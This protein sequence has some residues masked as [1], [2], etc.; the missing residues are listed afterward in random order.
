MA[1]NL[2]REAGTLGGC[3][4]IPGQIL[5]PCTSITHSLKICI[6]LDLT[7]G[8][9]LQYIMHTDS[10]TRKRHRRVCGCDDKVGN[11]SRPEKDRRGP[12]M[13]KPSQTCAIFDHLRPAAT[14]PCRLL[15]LSLQV[16]PSPPS[17]PSAPRSRHQC[18]ILRPRRPRN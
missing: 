6:G 7:T 12:C 14:F 4:S 13:T 2:S 8:P 18:P 10:P 5:A 1:A 17:S 16:S 9:I 11:V 15:R 3:S